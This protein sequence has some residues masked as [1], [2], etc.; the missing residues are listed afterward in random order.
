[1][2]DNDFWRVILKI[3]SSFLFD[4]ARNCYSALSYYN[5]SGKILPPLRFLCE[6]TYQCNLRC[7]F[8]YLGEKREKNELST[9]EWINV[10]KQI[11]RFSFLQL[12]GGEIFLRKDAFKLIHEASK[13]TF[14]KVGIV[15]NASLLTDENIEKLMNEKILLL[16]VSI[17]GIGEKHDTIRNKKGLY[18]QAVKALKRLKEKRGK[19]KY[20]LLEI[21]TVVLKDNLQDLPKLYELATDMN[22]D[23]LTFSFV[24]ETGLRQD[25]NMLDEYPEEIYSKRYPLKTYFDMQEFEDVYKNL[26]SIS[27][28]SN[29]LLRWAPKFKPTKDIKR[30]KKL[31]EKGENDI[32]TLY[33]PCNFPFHDVFIN[34]EGIVYPCFPVN[35]GSVREHKIMEIL[36]GKKFCEFRKKLR[37]EKVLNPCHL[38]CDLYPKKNI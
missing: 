18:E 36:N 9:E 34:P 2:Y 23:F 5:P 17:D 19:H 8:C 33:E 25:S 32:E 38:C 3:D 35:M 20:P 26:E 21:K 13:R 22:L 37:R 15:T 14:G 28:K 30:I 6:L 29:T 10:F 31:F 4:F 24:R 1:M 16:S 27:K 11:P 7:P 12:L